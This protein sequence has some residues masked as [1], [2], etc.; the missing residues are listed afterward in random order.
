MRMKL[1]SH[2]GQELSRKD[3]FARIKF[4]Y[5]GRSGCHLTYK[6]W[7][8]TL[9]NRHWIRPILDLFFLSFWKLQHLKSAQG[10]THSFLTHGLGLTTHW[11]LPVATNSHGYWR[12]FNETN[13]TCISTLPFLFGWEHFYITWSQAS[14]KYICRFYPNAGNGRHL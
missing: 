9:T 5:L 7:I 1:W 8:C 3:I 12:L 4:A 10:M 13:F 6:C 2:P 11:T 14:V